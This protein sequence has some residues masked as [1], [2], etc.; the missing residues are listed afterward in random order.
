[1]HV[2]FIVD[3]MRYLY[4]RTSHSGISFPSVL[5]HGMY[6]Y[7]DESWMYNGP[8]CFTVRNLCVLSL[9]CADVQRGI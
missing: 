5:I 6:H 1:M 9:F 2:Y 8:S 7:C 3:H 4:I